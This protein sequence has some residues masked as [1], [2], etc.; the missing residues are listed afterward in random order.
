MK[1]VL[2]FFIVII[3]SL[4]LLYACFCTR[5]KKI[6]PASESYN[7]PSDLEKK[8][9]LKIAGDAA[10]KVYGY[11]IIQKELPLVA[12]LK[13]IRFGLSPLLSILKTTPTKR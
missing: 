9:V 10:I 5:G 3:I 13:V 4:F 8:Q 11:D 12:K 1:K 6:G 2:S 7:K